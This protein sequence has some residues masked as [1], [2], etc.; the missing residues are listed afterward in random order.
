MFIDFE[1]RNGELARAKSLL[2]RAIHACPWVKGALPFPSTLP[3]SY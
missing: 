2:Y 3:D 1:L